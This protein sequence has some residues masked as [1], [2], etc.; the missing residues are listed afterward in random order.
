[1]MNQGTKEIGS[2]AVIKGQTYLNEVSGYYDVVSINKKNKQFFVKIEL[3]KPINGS[4]KKG[5]SMEINMKDFNQMIER[6][7]FKLQL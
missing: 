7:T 5:F 6:G 2:R 1:M 3:T 4:A